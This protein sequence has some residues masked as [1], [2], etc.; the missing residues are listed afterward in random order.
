MTKDLVAA[1]EEIRR[2]VTDAVERLEVDVDAHWERFSSQLSP[3]WAIR[4]RRR[5]PLGNVGDLALASNVH[6]RDIPDVGITPEQC[7]DGARWST[8]GRAWQRRT[9]ALA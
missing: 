7:G 8:T 9:A 4:P 3:I 1:D 5:R 6:P 2:H